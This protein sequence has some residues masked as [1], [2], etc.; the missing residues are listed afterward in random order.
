MQ[1][2][3][4]IED[5]NV[6]FETRAGVL[7]AVR[8]INLE[9]GPGEALALVGESG[10]GKSAAAQSVL[11]LLPSP[12]ARITRGGVFFAGENLTAM[13]EKELQRVRGRDIGF[14]FQDPMTSL[15]PTMKVGRQVVEVM[16]RH[17]EKDNKKN[18]ER[19]LE[20]FGLVGISNPG[21]R[22]DQY[23]HQLSGGMRQRVMAAIALA[24]GPRLLIADEPTTAVDVTIQA[25]IMELL[26]DLQ[27]K[28]GM[29]VLLITHDLSLV[30]GFARRVAVMY[31]GKIIET[32]TAEEVMN[33]PAHPYTRGL[34]ASI[35]R[36]EVR[37]EERLAPVPGRPPVMINPPPG[38]PFRPRCPEAMYIC[39]KIE[40]GETILGQGRIVSCWLAHPMAAES[41]P[42]RL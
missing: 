16:Y 20:I 5:L 4:K 21:R 11:K 24:C 30:A 15:N 26:R 3:L 27:K 22:L 9:I 32:G 8:G 17:G 35:P 42:E 12:P 41:R 31:A 6:Q 37:P 36:L 33:S 10:C 34:L 39:A 25:Q 1:P 2:L 13:S 18:R 38:C 7:Q 14:I 19:A 40:P 29:S 23:P 28:R